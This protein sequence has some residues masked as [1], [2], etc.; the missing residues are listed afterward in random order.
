MP[1]A[2]GSGGR[3]IDAG[4]SFS[5]SYRYG[6]ATEADGPFWTAPR[7]CRVIKLMC[8]T[9]GVASSATIDVKKAPSGT[10][11]GSGTSLLATPF[12]ADAT[13]N[14]NVTGTLTATAADLSLAAGD[15]LCCDVTGTLT[16]ATGVITVEMAWL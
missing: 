12:A 13:T 10:A 15:S 11:A 6:A 16:S 5:F 9:L 7:A 14:T 3:P 8:R 2:F 1:A 4:G